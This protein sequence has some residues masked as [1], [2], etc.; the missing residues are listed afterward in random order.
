MRRI[1]LGYTSPFLPS[2][3]SH[4]LQDRESLADTLIIVP[5]S[6]SG[7]ILRESL[8]AAAGAILSP[9]VATPGSLLHLEDPSIAPPW[10]EKIAW[11]EILEEIEAE[12]W[13]A[14]PDLFP[15]PPDTGGK[16]SD[17]AIAF[18]LEMVSLRSKLQDHRHNFFSASKFL[19]N[20]PEAGRWENLSRLETLAERKLGSWT[21]TSRST[22]LRENFSLPTNFTEIILAGITEMPPC[23]AE[24]LANHSGEVTCIIAAPDS[25]TANFSDLGIPLE[26]WAAR[27]LTLPASVS[28]AA[29]PGSQAEI[30]LSAIAATSAPSSEIALGCADEGASEALA[31]T[32][33]RNGWIAFDPAA[34]MPLPSLPRWLAAWREW[35]SEPTSR[36]LSALLCLPES[37]NFIPGDRAQTLLT[38]NQLRDKHP[39]SD[40]QALLDFSKSKPEA[41]QSI[42]SLLTHRT[43]FL[44]AD[45][46]A[47]I[48]SHLSTL[49]TSADNT[50]AAISDFL[51][52]ADPIFR[53]VT[54]SHTFWLRIL[55]SE[56]PSP[57]AQPPADRVIDIQGWLELLYEPG[58]HLVICGMN[59]TFVP[60]RSGG[61]PW[62]SE[63][64][65]SALSLNTDSNR[66][67]RDAYL[68]H[69]MLEMRRENG[70]A[71]LICTK[72]TTGN[73][74]LLPSRLLLQVPRADLVPAVKNLFRHTEPPE[75]NLIW[76]RDWKWQT[77]ASPP[78]ERIG[79]T[80]LRDYLACPFRYYLKNLA[81]MRTPE[82]E[83]REMNARDFGSI[84][85]LVLELWGKD[86]EA[87]LL[88]DPERLALWLHEKLDQIILQRFGKNPP[89]ALRIQTASIR[90]RLA[91]FAEEQCIVA[92]DGWELLHTERKIAI[93]TGDL[94]ING[95][96]DRIDRHRDTGQIRV[97]DYKT[98]DVKNVESEHRTKITAATNI[99]AHI[100]PDSAPIQPGTDAK[101]K[102]ATFLWKN[103][104]LPLYALAEELESGSEIPVPCYIHLG[105]T[106]S[107]VGFS[108]W[109]TFT[110]DDMN[111][112]H[113]CAD[114]IASRIAS[115]TFWPPSEKVTY[116]DFA[117]L[118]QGRPLEEAFTAP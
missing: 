63:S 95:M 2:L 86:P 49:R 34:A 71:H 35:L 81:H 51:A 73:Q 80:S 16:S 21:F 19:A 85:H 108:T 42:S 9:T 78:R 65:R 43:Q 5:T 10:L 57:P 112:A 83:R 48:T 89:L 24:A 84:T 75:A 79:V 20:T 97:I 87:R 70:S 27:E 60:A 58:E 29:D 45:F 68:L 46:S 30:A 103:L 111:S 66:H 102:P 61:E 117:Y 8:A 52:A 1:F 6:Q 105:K 118:S 76:E 28:L 11:I 82:P 38:I 26:T 12:E 14:Y 47:A 40:P 41:H 44:A 17:W 39:T 67:A 33:T 77:P 96:I 100:T 32:L 88:T 64:I 25:E 31:S 55:L 22:A 115:Q 7:R 104:Q 90:Q 69:A 4:L 110:R 113:S 99:P 92:S 98:G 59:E 36:N 93:P 54:R 107:N 3:V 18:A 50:T 56:I 106:R 23:L 62:L 37:A 114:W 101:G 74:S 109:E 91:W 53:K 72:T 13:G 15:T 94:V 116:D